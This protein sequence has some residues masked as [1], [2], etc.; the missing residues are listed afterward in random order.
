MSWRGTGSSR[1]ARKWCSAPSKPITG[2]SG[3]PLDAGN[4]LNRYLRPIQRAAGLDERLNLY[5][6]R[7]YAELAI[8]G[9][10]TLRCCSRQVCIRRSSLS[11]SGAVCCS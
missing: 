3:Q 4:L 5:S 6:L 1:T 10:R 2:S 9:I 8:S 7:H 11:G